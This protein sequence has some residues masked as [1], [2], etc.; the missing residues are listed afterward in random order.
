MDVTRV[1]TTRD[2][3][4]REDVWRGELAD[5][6]DSPTVVETGDIDERLARAAGNYW[7]GH[8]RLRHRPHMTSKYCHHPAASARVTT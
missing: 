4:P 1:P 3:L 8:V 2:P 7:C 6:Y 5:L